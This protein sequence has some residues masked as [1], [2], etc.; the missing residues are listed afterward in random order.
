MHGNW[1]PADVENYCDSCS[2]DVLRLLSHRS[3][4]ACIPV[5][6]GLFCEVASYSLMHLTLD[7]CIAAS[8]VWIFS[9]NQ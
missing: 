6:I 7:G 2:E 5:L 9:S 8:I 3:G 4:W 1:E